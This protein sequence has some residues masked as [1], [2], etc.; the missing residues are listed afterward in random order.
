[1]SNSNQYNILN[2]VLGARCINLT[3]SCVVFQ[4]ILLSLEGGGRG[5][6][7][8]NRNFPKEKMFASIFCIPIINSIISHASHYMTWFYEQ[9]L[10]LSKWVLSHVG[11]NQD[12]ILNDYW[13][14]FKSANIKFPFSVSLTINIEK[15]VSV[16]KTAVQ[17]YLYLVTIQPTAH[18]Q[19]SPHTLPKM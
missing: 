10:H 1:M 5:S 19:L 14:A 2:K 11:C 18:L 9:P 4:H 6:E 12:S 13:N 8:Y 3:M 17:H 7:S 16:W 15:A